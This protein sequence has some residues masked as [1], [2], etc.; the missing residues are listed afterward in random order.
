MHLNT[1]WYAHDEPYYSYR[2]IT[3]HGNNIIIADDTDLTK[4][5]LSE[6]CSF[7]QM[8]IIVNLLKQAELSENIGTEIHE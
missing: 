4:R 6:Y 3:P 2:L 1:K 8:P 7:G 5:Q